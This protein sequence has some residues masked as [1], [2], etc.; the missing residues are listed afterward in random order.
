MFNAAHE[1]INFR[2]DRLGN[3]GEAFGCNV[4]GP[5]QAHGRLHQDFRNLAQLLGA[6]E[7]IG[8]DPHDADGQHQQG[9]GVHHFGVRWLVKV[10]RVKHRPAKNPHQSQHAGYVKGHIGRWRCNL[11]IIRLEPG[12]F[13]WRGGH[14]GGCLQ[15]G[16]ASYF[17]LPFRYACPCD[18]STVLPARRFTHILLKA[19]QPLGCRQDD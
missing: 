12:H 17:C 7:E 3:G 4:L 6:P 2:A 18:A 16:D 14:A 10:W 9:N 5:D 15:A 19:Q 11:A 8:H 13:R 1:K